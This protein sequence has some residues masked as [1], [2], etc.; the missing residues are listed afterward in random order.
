[1]ASFHCARDRSAALISATFLLAVSLSQL[2]A[3]AQTTNLGYN[4]D[5]VFPRHCS[6]NSQRWFRCDTDPG[7]DTT[8][9]VYVSLSGVTGGPFNPSNYCYPQPRPTDNLD[10]VAEHHPGGRRIIWTIGPYT[11][12]YSWAPLPH[13]NW[14]LGTFSETGSGGV[15]FTFTAH[16]QP[17][18]GNPVHHTRSNYYYSHW[19]DADHLEWYQ[20][21]ALGVD[22]LEVTPNQLQPDN[23]NGAG[24]STYKFRVQYANALPAS[25]TFN[26]PPRWGADNGVHGEHSYYINFDDLPKAAPT[27]GDA[28]LAVQTGDYGS[29]Y[30][31]TIHDQGRG[32]FGV[33]RVPR[34]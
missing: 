28:P 26:L 22:P 4:G 7:S 3:V 20:S 19:D 18:S 10:G 15:R 25:G 34:L 12:G 23:D 17:S 27:V 14:C 24:D 2:P 5:G 21:P 33:Q 31:W 16:Y 13:Q 6:M 11:G 32:A 1:V 30:D 9:L 29:D 8:V